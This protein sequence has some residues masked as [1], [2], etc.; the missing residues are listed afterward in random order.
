MARCRLGA[1]IMSPPGK[2]PS[3]PDQ[4]MPHEYKTTRRVEFPD[5]D[6]AGIMHFTNF[7]K[8]MES[9]EHE[10]FRTHGLTMHDNGAEQMV[11][12]ARVSASCN[13]LRPAHYPDL[14]EVHL[15]V[16]KMTD[17]TIQYSFSFRVIDEADGGEPGPVIAKGELVVSHVAKSKD[18]ARMR[19][20]LI[21]EEVT[22]MIQ[23]APAES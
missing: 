15:L 6:M 9:A 10:F 14:L 2:P 13:Y 16:G 4:D 7:F 1:D 21:P 11:G 12:W 8:F 17:R 20:A 5:T 3:S 23:S 18:D 19:G 22:R